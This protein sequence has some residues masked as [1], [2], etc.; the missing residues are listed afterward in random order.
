MTQP[1]PEQP[2]GFQPY[3]PWGPP[4]TAPDHPQAVT[5]MVLGII[6]LVTCQLIGPFAWVMGARTLKEI[7]ASGG[8]WGGRS[9]AQIGYVLGIVSTC[10]VG[11]AV[12]GF[13]IFV[14][15]VIAAAA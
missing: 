13:L 8:R 2:P 3:T 14:A 6:S 11:L 1:P 4:L 7:D 9:Q 5:V 10:L 15:I 12:V